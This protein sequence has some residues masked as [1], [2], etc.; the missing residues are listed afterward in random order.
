MPSIHAFIQH[1][2]SSNVSCPTRASFLLQPVLSRP[3]N[4]RLP[5]EVRVSPL[6]VRS[7]TSTTCPGSWLMNKRG[8]SGLDSI[9]AAAAAPCRAV[10]GTH[11]ALDTGKSKVTTIH[12]YEHGWARVTCAVRLIPRHI[13]YQGTLSLRSSSVD[14]HILW[15]HVDDPKR[16][17]S[18]PERRGTCSA[19]AARLESAEQTHLSLSSVVQRSSSQRNAEGLHPRV[20]NA[21]SSSNGR[22]LSRS[23]SRGDRRKDASSTASS[24]W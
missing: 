14:R 6:T 20:D 8:S 21:A 17:R 13:Q 23:I 3:W 7:N 4:L 10:H 12:S 9:D 1:P 15:S 2:A 22:A 5:G 18:Q 24:S 19:A 11:A 16:T